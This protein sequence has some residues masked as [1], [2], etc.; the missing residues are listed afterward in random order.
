VPRLVLV[1]K[2]GVVDCRLD[3][4]L[5]NLRHGGAVGVMQIR[6]NTN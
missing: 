2:P 6:T 4:V 5:R 1:G 3:V